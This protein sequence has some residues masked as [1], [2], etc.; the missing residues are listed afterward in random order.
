MTARLPACVAT[1]RTAARP[2][3]GVFLAL[4]F[5]LSSCGDADTNAPDIQP[6]PDVPGARR[7]ELRGVVFRLGSSD[8]LAAPEET[9]GWMRFAHDAWMDTCETTQREFAALMGRNPSSDTGALL[10]VSDVTWYDAVLYANARSRRDGLDSVYE[11]AG[12][13]RDATGAA[14]GLD[15]F[16]ANLDR[17]G[18]RLPT[19]AEWEAAAR[20]GGTGAYAWGN[21]EDS[22]EAWS[23]AW[24]APNSGGRSHEVG[25]KLANAWGFHD[26]AGNVMEWV[27]DWKG[28]F[29]S[30]TIEGFSGSE[31]PGEV[32]EVPVK[33]GSFRH[34]IGSLRPSSRTATYPAYRSSKTEY[35]GFRLVRGGFASRTRNPSGALV[36]VPPVSILRKDLS[37][38]V[39]AATARLVFL[40]RSQGRNTLSWIDFG[41]GN[42]VVRSL[43][44][45]DP[46]FHPAISPDGRWVAWS[47]ALEGSTGPS[48]ILMRRL[49]AGDT[50]VLELGDG[51]IPRW[52]TEGP[53]TFLV[54]TGAMDNTAPGWPSLS[55]TARRWSGGT[56]VGPELVW[57]KGGYHDGRSGAF[58]FGGY[59]R[60]E[61][62]DI[63]S[64]ARSTLFVRPRNGKT[65]EDT[66]QVC[67]ASAAPDASGRVLFLDFGFSGTSTVVG[68]PYG[69]HEVAFVADSTG[70]VV[71]TLPAPVAERQWEHLEWSN[72]PRWAVSGAIT[73]SGAYANLYLLDLDSGRSTRIASGRELWHPALWVGDA[74]AGVVA[75]DADPDSSGAYNTPETDYSQEEFA[76]KTR[77]W[78]LAK[79]RVEIAAIGSSRVKAGI[80]PE[81]LGQGR[82]FNFGVSGGEP[83]MDRRV[84]EDYVLPHAPKLKV[85]IL[86]LMPGWLF[87]FRGQ[88]V[89]DRVAVTDGVRYDRDHGFWEGGLP[90]GFLDLV[91]RRSWASSR[92]F[93]SLGGTVIP[94]GKW[95]SVAEFTT[96]PAEDF[97]SSPFVENWADLEAMADSC[98]ARGIHLVIVNFPQAPVYATSPV[99]GKYGPTWATWK[100]IQSRLRALETAKPF[101]HFYDANM[102][103][104]HDY[105]DS[106]A[107]NADH[108]SVVGARILST[109]L[110]SLLNSIQASSP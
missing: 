91:R 93:D 99:M 57:A 64:G 89:W 4:A 98:S 60:L 19:E 27:H 24:F 1:W 16:V 46:A 11:H 63:R 31:A 95:G 84:L 65:D 86:S 68:R 26:L 54:R 21:G 44:H 43:P 53:D 92:S 12:I 96:P 72:R 69:I 48:R 62:L 50:T 15:A 101:L 110:D 108:L 82:A 42:P 75:G 81:L 87:Q 52:W 58:L 18:W 88:L 45:P 49:A 5:L 83:V 41:E 70:S 36:E 78:W 79:D 90:D 73:P 38:I 20:A 105:P 100:A 47:T 94:R 2:A 104:S 51:A 28:A 67:N 106:A 55:T 33:G 25:T 10:P 9:P 32:P 102:D 40:N 35:V 85:V 61:R 107:I 3:T 59:R 56:L 29:P 23:H 14:V 66:S 13:R 7:L 74:G 34:G 22:L 37:S 6:P 109:R 80:L 39:A 76:I 77:A 103:G 30:D 97:Q 71:K 17:D 8:P